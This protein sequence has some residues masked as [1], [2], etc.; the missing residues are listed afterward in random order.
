VVAFDAR[1]PGTD[2]AVWAASERPAALPALDPTGFAGVVVL[3]AHADD[4]TLG[5]GGL[6]A[7]AARAGVPVTLVVASDGAAAH[8]GTDDRAPGDRGADD[9]PGDLAAVR[10]A[11]AREAARRLGVRRVVQL[12]HPDG[13]LREARDLLAAD[14]AAL[15]RELVP[16][17]TDDGPA[18]RRATADGAPPHHLVLSTWRGDGHRDHRVLGEV[19]AEVVAAHRAALRAA[20]A[21]EVT[22]LAGYPVWAWHW[23]DPAHPDVP[24]DVMRRVDLDGAD[25]AAR[26]EALT[27]Y[28][29]QTTGEGGRPPVLHERFLAHADRPWDL[30]VVEPG[31]T[32]GTGAD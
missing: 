21:P 11:E 8:G 30:V 18:E 2:A 10:A 9:G 16:G 5:A 15:L 28:P 23:G 17:R 24:W 4:E 26:R 12:D 25:R 6:L 20:G 32:G 3:A 19:A 31:A 1:D 29:S 7:R 13:G 27:A 22:T 14:L